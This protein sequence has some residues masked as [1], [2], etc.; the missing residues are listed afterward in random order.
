MEN[1]V[2]YLLKVLGL[3]SKLASILGTFLSA[4]NQDKPYNYVVYVHFDQAYKMLKTYIID[5][6]CVLID[7]KDLPDGRWKLTFLTKGK[8]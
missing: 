4:S 1:L 3:V 5:K 8:T 6:H 2:N 7:I